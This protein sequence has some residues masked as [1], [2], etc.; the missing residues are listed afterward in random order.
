MPRMSYSLKIDIRLTFNVLCPSVVVC[1]AHDVVLAEI[2]AALHLDDVQRHGAGV[3]QTVRRSLGDARALV[4]VEIEDALATGD[5]R[6]AGR[7]DPVLAAPV[8][9]LERQAPSRL[10]RDALDLILRPLLQHRVAAPG[11]M[12]GLVDQ[13]LRGLLLA[14]QFHHLLDVLGPILGADQRGVG[15]VHHHHI[16]KS[17][18]G[19]QPVLA[20]EDGVAAAEVHDPPDADIAV[21][22]GVGD[23]VE[24]APVAD[25]APPEWRRNDGHSAAPLQRPMVTGRTWR[26]VPCPRRPAGQ[27]T[28]DLRVRGAAL[29]SWPNDYC[30]GGPGGAA[31]AG[32]PSAVALASWPHGLR[33]NCANWA[34]IWLMPVAQA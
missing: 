3:L 19:H 29:R 11:P 6:G 16:R 24:A 13:V 34:R 32:A 7:D 21:P 30:A 31:P 27:L 18:G 9:V 4:D 17:D 25:V 12:D 8:M 23:V 2:V 5:P 26:P 10:D 33:R 22:V 1:K 20:V 15:R 14:E 28:R